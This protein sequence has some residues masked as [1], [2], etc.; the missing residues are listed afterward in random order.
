MLPNRVLCLQEQL[1]LLPSHSSPDAAARLVRVYNYID[2]FCESHSFPPIWE[3]SQLIR[4]L[5]LF[6]RP[7]N[8]ANMFRVLYFLWRNGLNPIYFDRI[9]FVADARRESLR[10][11]HG[12]TTL[13]RPVYGSWHKADR[14]RQVADFINVQIPKM[15]R[16][17]AT[18]PYYDIHE[19]R[20]IKPKF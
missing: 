15:K 12:P 16:E 4:D 18:Y 3:W 14:I 5:L 7:L 19:H 9:V 11:L 6:G 17:G 20:V 10:G 2:D 13:W 8:N 1:A